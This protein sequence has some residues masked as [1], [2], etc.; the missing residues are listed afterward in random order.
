MPDVKIY[1]DGKPTAF[2]V[3]HQLQRRPR[4]AGLPLWMARLPLL[5]VTVSVPYIQLDAPPAAGERL[6]VLYEAA[7]D[8][9]APSVYMPYA[10]STANITTRR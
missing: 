3:A 10:D 1:I 6:M 9:P 7:P 2:H 4:F 8:E 5:G